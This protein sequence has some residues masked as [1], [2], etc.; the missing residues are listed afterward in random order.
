MISSALLDP[1]AFAERDVGLHD[2]QMDAGN[3]GIGTAGEADGAEAEMGDEQD[4]GGGEGDA[5]GAAVARVLADQQDRRGEDEAGGERQPPDA[6]ERG[7]LHHQRHRR[8]RVADRVPR[9]AGE[10]MAAQPFGDRQGHGEDEHARPAVATRRGGRAPRR[11]PRRAPARP[12][13]RRRRTASASRRSS[14]STRKAAPIHHRPARKKPKPKLQ[15]TSAAGSQPAERS[16]HPR[17]RWRRR[18]ARRR[19][20]R[21]ARGPGRR[22]TAAK[23]SA[24]SAPAT[25]RDGE[26]APAP[27]D[28]DQVGEGSHARR[29]PLGALS[30]RPESG[31]RGSG[32]GGP[33]SSERRGAAGSAGAS[34]LPARCR[35]RRRRRRR[36]SRG[37]AEALARCCSRLMRRGSASRISNS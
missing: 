7:R 23:A 6:D 34:R 24:D 9:E 27:Q 15:P 21:S 25:K 1:P 17:R 29:A 22:R 19:P 31:R 4:A 16:R 5:P 37:P 28:D 10:E 26:A 33:R 12:A 2:A 14:A 32:R 20:G 13:G 36:G 11:R 35:R 30:V 8:Q 3:R 18:S